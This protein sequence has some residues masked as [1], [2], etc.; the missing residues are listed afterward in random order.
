[1]IVDQHTCQLKI[2]S[3]WTFVYHRILNHCNLCSSSSS[4]SLNSRWI[5]KERQVVWP[6]RGLFVN[7]VAVSSPRW[8][9]GDNFSRLHQT[10]HRK[11]FHP[12]GQM[13]QS[14]P[15]RLRIVTVILIIDLLQ[16]GKDRRDN[17]EH[18]DFSTDSKRRSE[19]TSDT[20]FDD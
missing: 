4:R 6:R 17:A 3:P 1:M 7:V 9:D 5:K 15:S 8:T 11:A 14:L 18:R 20:L 19:A 2:V 12:F 10:I 13:A 16:G